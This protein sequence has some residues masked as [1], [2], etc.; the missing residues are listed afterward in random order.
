MVVNWRVKEGEVQ[1]SSPGE[2]TQLNALVSRL[3][4]NSEYVDS[5]HTHF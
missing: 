5:L 3:K 2:G 1:S 4:N